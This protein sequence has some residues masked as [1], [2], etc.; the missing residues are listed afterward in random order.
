MRPAAFLDRDGTVIREVDNLESLRQLRLLPGAASAI[1][2]L[3]RLGFLVIL[4]TNQPVVARGWITQLELEAIHEE[5]RRRLATKDARIDAIYYCPHHPN[6]NL[7]RY[8]KSCVC[9]K[10]NIGLFRKAAKDFGISM[11]RSF[12]IGDRTVD[13]EAGKRAGLQTILVHTGYKGRDGKYPASPDFKVK[14]LSQAAALIKRY[15]S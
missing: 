4:V 5:L 13:I 7:K 1:H 2:S 8:R 10:P 15:A 3:N 6:A 9:R 12:S 11:N 14:N